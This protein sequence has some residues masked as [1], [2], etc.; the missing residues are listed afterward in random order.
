MAG[1]DERETFQTWTLAFGLAGLVGLLQ[2]LLFSQLL[3]L[4]G[5]Q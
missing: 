4:A 1:F 5:S 3:P 2:V